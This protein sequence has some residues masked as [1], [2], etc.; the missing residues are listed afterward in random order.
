MRLLGGLKPQLAERPKTGGAEPGSQLLRPGHQMAR[1]KNSTGPDCLSGKSL[2]RRTRKEYCGNGEGRIP[3]RLSGLGKSRR[4]LSQFHAGVFSGIRRRRRIYTR[5]SADACQ[6]ERGCA[7]SRSG[8]L[9][10]S[11][12][13][14]G[15]KY[16]PFGR[17]PCLQ[18]NQRLSRRGSGYGD[19]DGADRLSR[20][21]RDV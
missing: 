12:K 17:I 2:G 20:L 5:E 9:L 14:L 18:Y 8:L 11:G 21:Y 10:H 7:E 4:N 15:R 3:R 1:K 13:F 16:R 6:H 19:S